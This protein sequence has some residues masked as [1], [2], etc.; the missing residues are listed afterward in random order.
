MKNLVIVESLAKAKTIEK[1]LNSSKVLKPLG[2][3]KVVASFGHVDNLPSKE[4]GIDVEK[5]FSLKYQILSDKKKT[6]DDLK[7]KAKD[8]DV[9]WLASDA[10]YEGEKI[11]D[12]LRNILK[13]KYKRVTFTEIT[14]HALETALQNPR[15]I[16]ELMVDAQETRRILDRLVGY[17][18]SPLLWK[19]YNAKG[20]SALSAGRVQS[21]VMHLILEREKE[22]DEFDS[23]CYWYFLGTFSIGKTKADDVRLYK[24]STVY[25][26]ANASEPPAMLKSLKPA[27]EITDVALKTVKQSPDAPFITS[28]FQQE[29]YNKLGMGIKRSM[30]IAQDLYENGFITYMRTDSYSMSD[31]FKAKAQEYIITEY[32]PDYWDGQCK[33]KNAK[34]AQAAHEAIRPTHIEQKELQGQFGPDHK[35]VYDLIWKRT[36]ASLMKPALFDELAISIK[37]AGLAKDMHFQTTIKKIKFNGYLAAYGMANEKY[38]IDA[39]VKNMR[40]VVCEKVVAKN[41]WSGPPS[42]FNDS[43]LVKMMESEGIGRPSTYASVIQKLIEKTYVIK[44]DVEGKQKPIKSYVLKPGHSIV[45]EASTIVVGAEKGRLVP[46]DIGKEID[47]FLAESFSYIIDKR[48]TSSMEA[49]LDHIAEGKKKKLDILRAFWTSFAKDLKVK[50]GEI[51]KADKVTLTAQNNVFNINGV[52]YKVRMAKFGPVIEHQVGDTKKFIGLNQYLK[53]VKKDYLSIDEN[54]INLLTRFPIKAKGADGESGTFELGPY[55]IYI[56]SSTG[57]HK[58]PYSLIM[59]FIKNNGRLTPEAVSKVI[60]FKKS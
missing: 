5:D 39:M 4:L 31:V 27:F 34:N 45:T 55:G 30:Q 54:D 28:S 56:K 13:R 51:L 49:D 16:D 29:A 6:V 40:G 9:V 33:R 59:E 7:A 48:F 14:Q 36:V 38:D 35:K 26:T 3:F 46:T 41:T 15:L 53:Y 37:N 17:K 23:E 1:Y 8:A 12:S 11:A 25:K 60:S 42:R 19:K 24:G 18:L 22:I 52:E 44:T 32:G 57:N 20:T 43:A 50:G 58:V 10:D 47:A 21:A 2:T